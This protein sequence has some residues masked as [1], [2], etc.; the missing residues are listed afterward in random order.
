MSGD[1]EGLLKLPSDKALLTD[2]VFRPLVDKYAAVYNLSQHLF[3]FLAGEV[4]EKYQIFLPLLLSFLFSHI[5]FH[6]FM[7][8]TNL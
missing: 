5:E 7:N 3:L 8:E 2:P 1:K 6:T 4:I